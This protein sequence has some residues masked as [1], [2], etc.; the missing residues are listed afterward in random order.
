MQANEEIDVKR[1]Y[2]LGWGILCLN[3]ETWTFFASEKLFLVVGRVNPCYPA[4][5]SSSAESN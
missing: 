5:W 3:I 4:F 1:I 2:P